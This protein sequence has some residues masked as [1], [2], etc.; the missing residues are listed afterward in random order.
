MNKHATSNTQ[1]CTKVTRKIFLTLP[2]LDGNRKN[3]VLMKRNALLFNIILM[4]LR[5]EIVTTLLL[6]QPLTYF[7]W[8]QMWIWMED[9][10]NSTLLYWCLPYL[11][12]YQFSEI[13]NSLCWKFYSYSTRLP[14]L[15]FY[16]RVNYLIHQQ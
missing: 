16:C 1:R 10:E 7:I 2:R 3:S 6:Y 5:S 13:L 4:I 8:C 15:L 11:M 9:N 12:N 14:I